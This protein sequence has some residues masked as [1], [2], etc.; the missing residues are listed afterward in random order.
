MAFSLSRALVP[1]T[2]RIPALLTRWAEPARLPP[3]YRGP[4]AAQLVQEETY[5]KNRAQVERRLPDILGRALAR[6][7]IDPGFRVRFGDDPKGTLADYGVHLPETIEVEFETAGL[8]R[9]QVVVYEQLGARDTRK[10][11][12]YLQLVMVAG[13]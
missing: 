3:P 8:R 9:P 7:W 12:L 11:L 1:I 13:R 10:R 5:L 6:I 2:S 4:V